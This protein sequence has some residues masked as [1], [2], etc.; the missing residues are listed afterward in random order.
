MNLRRWEQLRG[1]GRPRGPL[2]RAW[3]VPLIAGIVSVAAGL[4]VLA[5]PWTIA[6]LAV[7]AG[8]VFIFRGVTIALNALDG[9]APRWLGIIAGVSGVLA[10]IWLLAWPGP[11]LLVLAVFIG[12]WLTVSGVF[13]AVGAVVARREVRH[14]GPM[15]AIGIIEVLLGMWAMRRP[16]LS[17]ALAVTVLGFWAV[18]T[19]ALYI[20]VALELRSVAEVIPPYGAN[21]RTAAAADGRVVMLQQLHQMGVLSDESLAVLLAGLTDMTSGHRV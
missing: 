7:F 3:L 2:Q 14:W 20:A 5:S 16:D 11:S 13:N 1:T 18:V 9:R 15:L 6:Q 8:F 19:G 12:A 21:G 17:L 4:V 10:G